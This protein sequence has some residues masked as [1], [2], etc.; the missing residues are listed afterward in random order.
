MSLESLSRFV[1]LVVTNVI[2][3]GG[4]YVGL[5]AATAPSP[6]AVV[7]AYSAFAMG[8][9]QLGETTILTFIERFFGVKK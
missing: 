9:A 1:T 2:K 6:N 8:G 5:R 7:L 4:L 3:V